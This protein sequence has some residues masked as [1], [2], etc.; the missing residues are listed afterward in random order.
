MYESGPYWFIID[1]YILSEPPPEKGDNIQIG[2]I[3]FGISS[4]SAAGDKIYVKKFM[5]CD[6]LSI[7]IAK[8]SAVSE[9]S[10]DKNTSN[11]FLAPSMKTLNMS[12]FLIKAKT[13]I[14]KIK[15]GKI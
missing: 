6:V 12:T 15:T 1:S 7:S 11:P 5:P 8:N 13:M 14:I 10:I 4:K 9:G 2:S 3:S